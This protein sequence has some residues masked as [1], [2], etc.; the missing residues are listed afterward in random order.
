MSVEGPTALSQIRAVCDAALPVV[1]VAAAAAL[2]ACPHGISQNLAAD[3][4]EMTGA[5]DLPATAEACLALAE[6]KG[7]EGASHEDMVLA[8]RA[9]ERAEELAGGTVDLWAKQARLLFLIAEP[10][11]KKKAR[12]TPYLVRG[13]KLAARIKEAAPHRVEGHYYEAA[14]LGFQADVYRMQAL[15]LLPRIVEDGE[16]AIQID[17]RFDDG[18]ALVLMGMVL[19]KAPP[20][21]L[22]VGDSEEGLALL[23]RSVEVS[24]Y[25]LNR[26]ILAKALLDQDE[27]TEACEHLDKALLAPKVGRWA[28]TWARHRPD[29]WTL[30]NTY[31]CYRQEFDPLAQ[32][33]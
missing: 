20:W 22:G 18:G 24:A 16:R 25:P 13:E 31:R 33:H 8:L 32:P 2:A 5:V 6:R 27:L 26:I 3:P 9:L 12:V 7:A 30:W 15:D 19:I 1:V 23:R 21:P 14:F 29:A 10:I 11:A 4:T 28:T 17:E